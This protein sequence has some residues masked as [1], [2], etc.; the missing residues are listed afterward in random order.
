MTYSPSIDPT[1]ITNVLD[2]DEIRGLRT[3]V[4]GNKDVKSIGYASVENGV[5]QENGNFLNIGE[6]APG[7]TAG[8]S[9]DLQTA[10]LDPSFRLV[11]NVKIVSGGTML[12]RTIRMANG[13][14]LKVTD[15]FMVQSAVLHQQKNND[16]YDFTWKPVY[17]LRPGD[18]VVTNPRPGS[19]KKE[20][21]AEISEVVSNELGG[22]ES[23]YA[24]VATTQENN[25]FIINGVVSRFPDQ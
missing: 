14:A 16:H 21:Q 22:L 10:L 18:L 12:V 6:V 17:E 20:I 13:R 2:P 23:V 11:G 9:Q 19:K 5:L 15:G 4:L 3:E 24:L 1:S 25:D 8:E 7:T